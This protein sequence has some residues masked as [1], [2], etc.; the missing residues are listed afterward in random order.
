MSRLIRGPYHVYI[1]NNEPN[2]S[3]ASAEWV[4]EFHCK[5]APNYVSNNIQ[6]RISTWTNHELMQPFTLIELQRVFKQNNNTSPGK[7]QIHYSMLYQLPTTTKQSLLDIFNQIY[8]GNAEIPKDWY[9]YII[10]PILKPGKPEHHQD[11]YRPIALASCVLKTYGRL[12]KNRLEFYLEKNQLPPSSQY[13]FRKGRST[14]D[15]LI[16]LTTDIQIGFS[17]NTHT[18]VIFL[19]VM[20]AYDNVDLNILYSKII[21]IGLPKELANHLLL[22]Y[23]NRN[24]F[25]RAS[26]QTIGPR[27][28]SKGLAQGSILSPILYII[29]SYDFERAFNSRDAKIYQF[30]DDC[31]INMQNKNLSQPM[32][33]LE[34]A[35]SIAH[36]WFENNGSS[37]AYSKS[38][39]CTFTRSRLSPS[40]IITLD[41]QNISYKTSVKYLG[42]IL[43]KK[44][45]W[46]E[47]ITYILKRSQNAFNILKSFPHRK[48]GADPAVC[49]TFYRTLVRSILDYGSI[50]YGNA[51]RIHL[52]K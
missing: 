46:K 9:D 5:L 29:Y 26:E 33:L 47:H 27:S 1:E 18:S 10:I 31:A 22:P 38:C 19:D 41:G 35:T 23:S 7:D 17:N 44:L 30:A 2:F 25:I 40:N 42:A 49:L 14:Q 11:S 51:S 34:T 39:V 24:I 48:W 21:N 16:Q 12:I 4:Q 36:E 52:Q 20:G 15:L 28:T 13:R 50:L 45:N 8:C 32:E 6:R 37:I 3:E 43:D